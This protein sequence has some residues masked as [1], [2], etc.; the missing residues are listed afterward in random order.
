M[1]ED[2][3]V[4]VRRAAWHTLEDGGSP[5]DPKLDPIF[6]RVWENETDKGIRAFVRQLGASRRAKEEVMFAV[7][8]VPEFAETG[9]C[10]FCETSNT[11]V[12]KD[13]DTEIPDGGVMR[14]ALVCKDCA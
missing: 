7:Q 4:L 5:D 13:F 11:R 14:I 10:D 2:P 8:T 1:L 3:N 6:A 9:K 12:K